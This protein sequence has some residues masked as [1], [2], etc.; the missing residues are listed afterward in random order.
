M[1][2]RGDH[3]NQRAGNGAHYHFVVEGGQILA[4]TA[5]AA[6]DDDLG[7]PVFVQVVD[8]R[9]DIQ[10]GA[11]A[12][13]LGRPHDDPRVGAALVQEPEHVVHRGALERGDHAD[14][15]RKERQGPLARRGEESFRGELGL[16]LLQRELLLAQAAR[17]HAHRVDLQVAAHRV[18]VDAAL[19]EY[20]QTVFGPEAQQTCVA[21]E[22]HRVELALGVLEREIHVAGR[23]DAQPGNLPHDPHSAEVRLQRALNQARQRGH[24]QDARARQL[25]GRGFHWRMRDRQS[26]PCAPATVVG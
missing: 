4:R 23:G 25:D 13:H 11:R 19:D 18:Q 6:D 5:P 21:A 16:E 1:A 9:G 26:Y 17:L 24:R 3:R 2:D 22:H 10:T 14:A 12:L 15:A 8:A 7:L 20:L